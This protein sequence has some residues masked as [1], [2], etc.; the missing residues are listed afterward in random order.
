MAISNIHKF[1]VW[2]PAMCGPV[3][4]EEREFHFTYPISRQAARDLVERVEGFVI[5]K[6]KGKRRG[7]IQR[8]VKYRKAKS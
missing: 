5:E 3:L 6:K 8:P 2:H 4:Y 7:I 1:K